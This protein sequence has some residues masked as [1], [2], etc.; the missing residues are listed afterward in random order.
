[1]NKLKLNFFKILAFEIAV[2]SLFSCNSEANKE[3]QIK[4]AKKAAVEEYVKTL[5][6]QAKISQLFLV[7]I[8]GNTTFKAVEKTAGLY[9]GAPEDLPLVPG[10]CLLFS[11]NIGKT[12][13]Q[14]KNFTDS[15]HKFYAENDY[16][17]PYISIDQEG[18][19]V[20]RLRGIAPP[21]PSA[22]EISQKF[23][24]EEA[25]SLY[26]KQAVKMA[27]LGINLDL[28]PVIEVETEENS[29]FLDTR[30]FGSLPEVLE[31][32]QTEINIF[33]HLGIGT[34]LKHF[35]GNTN[36]DPH[37]GLP[38]IKVT[39]RELEEQLVAPFKALAPLSSAIL[40]SHARI[41]LA[42]E[43]V[44]K[45]LYKNLDSHT[46]A[47][48]S[49]FWVTDVVRKDFGFEGLILSDDIFMGA[50]RDNGFPPEKAAL[51]AIEA[52]IDVIMLS[53]KRF[54]PVAQ[55]LLEYGA[56][57]PEFEAKIT[58]AC[59]RVVEYKIKA[60]LIALKPVILDQNG[61]P[62]KSPVFKVEVNETE[63]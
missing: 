12:E 16:P 62:L 22:K 21:F 47:C 55:I 19:Y 20:N 63:R 45:P 7:N 26:K 4:A 61:K 3:E 15:I 11:Y 52:G 17:P 49:S 9:T 8:E 38:E 27:E 23:S 50:L 13:Q 29:A 53:E 54:G 2:L 35:P 18:G 40:M 30:S 1:M 58:E 31:Y 39:E 51:Q 57:N 43:N 32:G 60:G 24:V 42:E 36:T 5:S 37:T 10:G 56:E 44:T 46:P 34:V 14:I 59:K 33:E 6:P 48:L 41:S 25:S 28:A